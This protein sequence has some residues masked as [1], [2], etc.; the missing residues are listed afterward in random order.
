[1]KTLLITILFTTLISC[2]SMDHTIAKDNTQL[3]PYTRDK[4]C[5][6][7]HEKERDYANHVFCMENNELVKRPLSYKSKG[8]CLTAMKGLVACKLNGKLM[9]REF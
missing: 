5:V 2:E 4:N 8:N 3:F 9:Y 6:P 7:I 1:M